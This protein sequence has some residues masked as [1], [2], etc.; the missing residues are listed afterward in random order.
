MSREQRALSVTATLRDRLKKDT[1]DV[2][3]RLDDAVSEL[4]LSQPEQYRLFLATNADAYGAVL[5]AL[6]RKSALATQIA[7][8][9]SL[10]LTDLHALTGEHH[11]SAHKSPAQTAHPLG[12]Q[13]VL[14]GSHFGK[15]VLTKR[16]SKSADPRVLAAGSFLH[17]DVLGALW[18]LT[19]S[20]LEKINPQDDEANVIV[21]SAASTFD[22]FYAGLRD[23]HR[24]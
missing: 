24:G 18:P 4:D 6:P 12:V 1:D 7:G 14:A 9:R 16:W 19:L 13:Y 22:I 2:H 8:L 21:R 5:S 20:A 10:M 15:R 23:Y 3:R 11:R 17:N